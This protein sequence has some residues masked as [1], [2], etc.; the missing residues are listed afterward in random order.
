M[1]LLKEKIE[2]RQRIIGMHVN[3]SDVTMGRIAGSGGYD[4]VWVDM[5]HGYLSFESLLQ[6]ILA[7]KSA[8][9][10]VIV[11]VP[12]HDLTAT[13]K[14]LEMGPDGIIFPM[15][16]SA[17]EA[18]ELLSYT[19]Y[20]PYG[21]RGFGPMNAVDYGFKDIGEYLATNHKT[22]CRF[23]Q[24]EHVNAVRDLDN[25]IKNEFIDGYIIGANDLSGSIG[26]LGDIYGEDTTALIK[27][28]ISKLKANG[29]YVGVSTGDNSEANICY[30]RDMGID[31][32]SCGTDFD[33][34]TAAVKEN[35]ERLERLH[36][37]K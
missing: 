3:L 34:L 7:I 37:Q 35:K 25:I 10:Q 15:V 16:K 5:E 19:L 28:T 36:L 31:M 1:M 32:M 23:I 4:F 24:I 14:V 2:N 22:M 8:G 11:R 27:E 13:K 20:P 26:Q 6:Q 12:Q 21:K 17:E 29:K 33:F 18:N 9:S 30:W